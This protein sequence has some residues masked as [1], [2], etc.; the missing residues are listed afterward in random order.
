MLLLVRLSI[1]IMPEYQHIFFRQVERHNIVFGLSE[2][3]LVV[4]ITI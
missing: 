1:F 4:L 2:R 3:S